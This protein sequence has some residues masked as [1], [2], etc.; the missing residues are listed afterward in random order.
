MLAVEPEVLLL[1][2]PCGALDPT[3]TFRIKELMTE[4]MENYAIIIVTHN[5]YQ[6]MGTL[7]HVD[8]AT[9]MARGHT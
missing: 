3:A 5:M 8:I 1:D 4:L 2:E 6:A 7:T 9:T